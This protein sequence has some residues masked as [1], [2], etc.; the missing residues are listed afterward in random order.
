MPLF[1]HIYPS[2]F[3]VRQS[4]YAIFK[5]Q[6]EFFVVKGGSLS[7]WEEVPLSRLNPGWTT[8]YVCSLPFTNEGG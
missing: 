3:T 8:L 6:I 5:L 4:L 1:K 7:V 2:A